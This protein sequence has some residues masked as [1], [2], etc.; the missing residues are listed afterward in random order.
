MDRF[1]QMSQPGQPGNRKVS[2]PETVT[3][4]LWVTVLIFS[5]LH[6]L[7][8]RAAPAAD[9][10]PPAPGANA[11]EAPQ[12]TTSLVSTNAA[13]APGWGDQPAVSQDGR[14]TAFYSHSDQLPADRNGYGDIYVYDRLSG[15]TEVASVTTEG[16]ASDHYSD[17][18]GVSADGSSV[19]FY[20]YAFNLTGESTRHGPWN[21][22]VRDRARG[23]TVCVSCVDGD[24]RGSYNYETP[25]SL[26]SSGRYVAFTS[27]NPGLSSGDTDSVLDVFVADRDGNGN[28]ILD[29]ENDL[30]VVL[31][32]RSGAGVKGNM[33]SSAPSI[34]GDGRFVAFQ[35]EATNLAGDFPGGWRH[36]YLHD[37]DTDQDGVFDEPGAISTTLVSRPLGGAA[38][39]GYSLAPDISADGGF[40]AFESSDTHLAAGDTNGKSDVFVYLRAS[41]TLERA[42]VLSGGGQADME[43]TEASISGDGRRVLFTG[44]AAGLIPGTPRCH[45]GGG[46]CRAV[47]LHD[48]QSGTTSIVS[49]VPI[50]QAGNYFGYYDDPALSPEGGWAG[51]L[52]HLDTCTGVCYGMSISMVRLQEL[53]SGADRFASIDE[54]GSQ[55]VRAQGTALAAD[56]SRAAYVTDWPG[57]VVTDTN[58]ASD[59]FVRGL[60]DGQVELGSAGAAGVQGNAASLQPALSR[61]GR[62]L[63]FQSEADNLAAGDSN[64][65]ADIF[66]RELDGGEAVRLSVGPGGVQANGASANPSISWDGRYV[67]FQS[68]ASNLAAGDSNSAAD[69]FVADRDPDGDG[70]LDEAGQFATRRVSISSAGAQADNA[71]QHPAISADGRYVAFNSLASNLV[72]GD[73]NGL[74]DVFVHDRDADA[75]GILDEPGGVSTNRVSVSSAGVQGNADSGN[76]QPPALSA[77]GRFV[78]FASAA[79]SLVFSDTAQV[80]IFLHDRRLGRTKRISVGEGGIQLNKDSDAPAISAHGRYIA[81]HSLA[82]NLLPIPPTAGDPYADDTFFY[83]QALGV[84]ERAG[85]FAR[86]PAI[87]ADGRRVLY[88]SSY[89]GY[90]SSHLNET[91]QYVYQYQRYAAPAAWWIAPDQPLLHDQARLDWALEEVDESGVTADMQARAEGGGVFPVASGEPSLGSMEWD[92]TAAPDGVYWLDL[93]FTRSGQPVSQASKR[94]VIGN[95]LH[96]ISGTISANQ[97]WGAGQ[98]HIVEA[99]AAIPSGVQVTVEPWAVVK[100]LR[101]TRLLVQNGGALT[102]NGASGQAIIFTSLYD[103][104]AG[105]DT[106]QDGGE[107][108]PAPG[109]WGGV[110]VSGSGQFLYNSFTELRYLRFTHGG[111]LGGNEIWGAPG[112]H[113]LSGDVTIPAGVT[114]SINPGAVVKL[115]NKKSIIVQAGGRI[116]AR[117]NLAQP[118]VFTSYRDDSAGGDTDGDGGTSAAQPGDWQRIN[119]LGGEADFEHVVLRY[120]GG[121]LSGGWDRSGAVRIDAK[122]V[123]HLEDSR[124]EDALFEGVVAYP[125][126]LETPGPTAL[127]TNTVIARTDRGVNVDARAEA[128]LVNCTL[129]DNRVGI[130]G[131]GGKLEMVNTIVADSHE[132]GVIQILGSSFTLRANDVWSASGVNYAGMTDPTGTNGNLS[133]DPR[134]K[135]PDGGDYRLSYL[136]PA[137]DAADGTAAPPTDARGAPRYDDPRSENTGSGSPAYAD[138]GAFEFVE[139]A[140]SDID[141]AASGVS[142]P[143]QALV[144]DTAVVHWTVTNQGSAPAVGPWHDQLLLAQAS[145]ETLGEIAI[146]EVTAGA[147]A[148]LGPGQSLDL[149]A[150]VRIPGAVQGRY[151]WSVRTNIY[152]E[153]FEGQNELNNQA[154]SESPLSLDLLE[155]EVDG[156]AQSGRFDTQSA[157][158]WF[159]LLP[160]AGEDVLLRLQG[161]GTQG[162]SALFVGMGYIPGPG[163]YLARSEP[164]GGLDAAVYLPSAAEQTYYVLA[165][166]EGLA[167]EGIDFSLQAEAADFALTSVEPAAAGDSGAVTFRLR[168]GKLAADMTYTLVDSGGAAHPPQQVYWLDSTQVFATFD[169]RGLPA[170][171]AGLRASRGAQAAELPGAVQVTGGGLAGQVDFSIQA[172]SVMRAGASAPVS[173]VYQNIGNTD[174]PAPLVNLNALSGGVSPLQVVCDPSMPSASCPE[175][176]GIH[177]GTLMTSTSFMAVNTNGPVGTLPPGASGR[178]EGWITSAADQDSMG[179]E[180]YVDTNPQS[181]I[182][183]YSIKDTL[184]PDWTPAAAWEV[185]FNQFVQNVGSSESQ[186]RQ[187]MVQDAQYLA[188]LEILTNDLAR[189]ATFELER[190][191]LTE[192]G[193]RYTLGVFGYGG[194]AGWEVRLN[195]RSNGD[196]WIGTYRPISYFSLQ[197]DGTYQGGPGDLARLWTQDG[198]TNYQE[199][200]GT[201]SHFLAN[202]RLDYSQDLNG[203]RQTL[204]YSGAR[205]VGIRDTNGYSLD[206]EYNEFG[207]V[208]RITDS[209]GKVTSYGYDAAGEHLTWV[210]SAGGTMRYTYLSGQG[211]AREHAVSSITFPSGSHL[212]IEYDPQ[213]RLSRSSM[214]GGE[215]PMDYAYDLGYTVSISTPMGITKM[216]GTDFGRLG[217][218]TDPLGQVTRFSYNDQHQMTG[219]NQPLGVQTNLAYDQNGSPQTL[220][221][222][223]NTRLDLHFSSPIRRLLSMGDANGNQTRFTYDDR[224]NLDEIEFPDGSREGFSHDAQGNLTQWVGRGGGVVNIAYNSY[225][226]PT[227]RAYGGAADAFVYDDALQLVQAAHTAPG[228]NRVSTFDYDEAGRPVQVSDPFGRSLSYTYTNQRLSQMTFSDGYRVDYAYDGIGRLTAVSDADGLLAAYQYDLAGNLKRMDKGSGAYSLYSYNAAGRL[229]SLANHAPSGI[230]S[231]Q[232]DLTYDALGRQTSAASLDG[233][234]DYTY[235][236]NSQL[237]R[238]VFTSNSPGIA[239]QDLAY[240]YDPAGNL[241]RMTRNGGSED[242]S[243]NQLN[244]YTRIG[245]ATY[246]YN[247]DGAVV[248]KQKEG[249]SWI[250]AYDTT[251]HLASATTP[252]GSWNFEYDGLGRRV[253]QVH[254]G[255]RTEY[256]ASPALASNTV[257]SYGPAGAEHYVFGTGLVAVVGTGGRSY[258]D[259]DAGGN[260]AALVDASGAVLNR[261]VY[262]PFGELLHSSG[263]T[264]NLFTFGGQFGVM[265]GPTAGMFYMKNRWYDAGM[266]RFTQPDALLLSGGDA[267]AYRYAGNSPIDKADPSG[268]CTFYISQINYFGQGVD[269]Y[270]MQQFLIGIGTT[271][272]MEESGRQTVATGRILKPLPWT[273]ASEVTGRTMQYVSGGD[274]V[275]TE[276]DE[277]VTVV[278]KKAKIHPPSGT[279]EG[280]ADMVPEIVEETTRKVVK[281][282]PNAIGNRILNAAGF[283]VRAA[284]WAAIVYEVGEVYCWLESLGNNPKPI[285][286]F[287]PDRLKDAWTIQASWVREDI[288]W[289]KEIRSK[290]PNLKL[291]RGAGVEGFTNAA[292]PLEYTILFENQSSATAPAQQVVIE[293][294]LDWQLDPGT[295]ELVAFGF[296]R[297]DRRVLPGQA[298]VDA[299]LSVDTDPNPVRVQGGLVSGGR[300]RWVMQSVDANTLQPVEDP[301]AGFLPPNDALRRGEGFVTFRIRPNGGLADGTQIFNQAGITFDVNPVINTPPVT[302]TLDLGAPTATVGTLPAEVRSPFRVSWSGGDGA[303]G[304][305]VASFDVYVSEDGGAYRLWRSAMQATSAVFNGAFQKRYDFFATA[306]DAAGNRTPAALAAQ[307]STTVTGVTWALHLPLLSSGQAA[308]RQYLPWVSTAGPGR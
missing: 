83:D 246:Q 107:I 267:N 277:K 53:G 39:D 257:A 264:L 292:E 195:T 91:Y 33:A 172:P 12:N 124:I 199:P 69:I 259:F 129:H 261:Y 128:R 163:R 166:G 206:I 248:S 243:V 282:V 162:S 40:V 182:D 160:A 263:S 73:T 131:H 296:N 101:G 157:E 294:T 159:K 168:G 17:R 308:T 158:H 269:S 34:S 180:L 249:Q 115:A 110:G 174:A 132:Q 120:G 154:W 239:A 279:I 97:T 306:T 297:Q 77:D 89:T 84:M 287:N 8:P 121:S 3:R 76:S 219:V 232:F 93:S 155:L 253:A 299:M 112:V 171:A 153:V 62:T 96:W 255:Q 227:S 1:L 140:H 43:S 111:V 190:A 256:L 152:G 210:T 181:M 301:L 224:Y 41:G 293:D 49:N 22:I 202:G 42:S 30:Q 10:P 192:V 141:L 74:W 29:E 250:Y 201:L 286:I 251:G 217:R 240:E 125:D 135:N 242:Y 165:R 72:G 20:S 27:D 145:G 151:T 75:D 231:S 176:A 47:L 302:N 268:L 228:I 133:A 87:S 275:L 95:G 94:V 245:T 280:G 86:Q 104:S 212:Y 304:S 26:S 198:G 61:D 274:T 81:F 178:V 284:G 139:T 28:G 222:P 36:I 117:G 32:S 56:G 214:D 220:T 19:A 272:I 146:A 65:A 273:G 196:V 252:E 16:T 197:E 109:D 15:R 266:S 13:G 175:S 285:D 59:V 92:T 99:D 88:T 223:K 70:I 298:Q 185:V 38:A 278:V 204:E 241:L 51:Y 187:A 60:A 80:D 244:Q 300:L 134:L 147:G 218:L 225:N 82:T 307:A 137:I 270:T 156:A 167:G 138:L 5:A 236:A 221:L 260:V 213:G 205:V 9:D 281:K 85:Q 116:Q 173:V 254:N 194:L 283:F 79:S 208:S 90:G 4:G 68:E 126:S 303:G 189:L 149:S 234:W 100:F 262:A 209:L 169:M 106:L 295:L 148:A 14:I 24:A 127:L 247:A 113:S 55:A 265:S 58:E 186:F 66:A 25:P 271:Q 177:S 67:A 71:S 57:V 179:L 6:P 48:R 161:S 143:E 46:I 290:D 226:L 11:P 203:N 18:P 98:V 170:G 78:A 229:V 193:E 215:M 191:G 216:E 114:L 31:V 237:T 200:G 291:T 35:S 211:A 230:V 150:E 102:A 45:T 105:G 142:G 289:I 63:A 118:V 123:L 50:P 136:S 44:E 288:V 144:G 7:Q 119:L 207:R 52:F 21:L 23:A 233:R 238:A 188:G 108:P 64:G 54:R 276:V 130:W 122:G 164:Q 184:K 305:G 258:Y 235:D 103:D 37:R 183:W 2:W